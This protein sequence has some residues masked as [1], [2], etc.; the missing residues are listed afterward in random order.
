MT[1]LPRLTFLAALV[2]S[3]SALAQSDYEREPINYLTAPVDDPVARLQKKL[4]AGSARLEWNDEHGYLPSLLK[5]LAVPPSSQTLVFS[6]TSFQ[7][8]RISPRRPRAIYFSDDAY[9]GWV[10][11]GDVLEI[12]AVDPQQG[13]IFYSLDQRETDRPRFVRQ[14]DRCLICHSS[15]HT[16]SV[17]G[18]IVRSVY[19]EPSGMPMFSAGT[20]RTD[21]TSPFKERWGGWYVSGTHG[22]QR[23]MGNEVVRNGDRQDL[24]DVDAGANC[25]DLSTRFDVRPYLTP[26][27]DLVALMV[28]EHQAALHNRITAA[29]F[30]GRL[31]LRDSRVMNEAFGQPLDLVSAST[32]RRFDSA[33]ERVLEYLL[34]SGEAALTDPIAGTS[35]FTTEFAA[36]G[37]RDRAGRS[38]RDFDLR[39]RMFRYPCSFLIYSEAFAGLPA[40]VKSAVY[41]RLKQVLSGTDNSPR[42]AHLSAADRQATIEILRDTLKDLPEGW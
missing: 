10:Q 42:F 6:K 40:E 5:Q 15:G 41:R 39:T 20:F 37:P 13:G 22:T 38:L 3:V 19:P 31:A 35:S 4:E 14:T 8:S 30:A 16:G 32:Q 2:V 11:N 27:S 9:I 17:P 34:F 29:N 25:T 24:L 18:H 36:L 23:H 33:A 7:I 21:P 26:H 1:T 12:T 28:L